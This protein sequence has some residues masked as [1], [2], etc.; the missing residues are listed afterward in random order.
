MYWCSAEAGSNTEW[1]CLATAN[2]AWSVVSEYTTVQGRVVL[3]EQ[4][5]TSMRRCVSESQVV[6]VGSGN[7]ASSVSSEASTS[8]TPATDVF[9]S[10][11]N[12][13]LQQLG[14]DPAVM[15]WGS[16][17]STHLRDYTSIQ[18]T[19]PFRG[20]GKTSHTSR[21]FVDRFSSGV[22]YFPLFLWSFLAV[23]CTWTLTGLTALLS[24]FPN[25][26]SRTMAAMTQ[27][28]TEMSTRSRKIM[29]LGSKARPVRRADN[30]TA[31][32]EPTV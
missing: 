21:P 3:Q 26:S 5:A 18:L 1:W 29:F 15:R 7:S 27:P 25:P 24:F 16:S 13:A 32:C 11:A 19:L 4:L 10:L 22:Q 8:S 12:G 14:L 23:P 31:I 6:V 9:P 20:P 28:L 17:R 30:L 2:T